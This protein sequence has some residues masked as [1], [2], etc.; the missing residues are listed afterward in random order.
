MRTSVTRT[1]LGGLLAAT[2]GVGV[3]APATA[4]PT[5]TV[6]PGELATGAAPKV[7]WLDSANQQIVRPG[8]SPLT[9]PQGASYLLHAR[10]GYVT[11]VISHI[12]RREVYRIVF[13]GDGGRRR[14]VLP[15]SRRGPDLVSADGRWLVLSSDP[16]GVFSSRQSV[17][18]VRIS[19]GRTV[20][21]RTFPAGSSPTAA[22][23]GRVVVRLPGRTVAWDVRKGSTRTLTESGSARGPAED[24]IPPG[25][26]GAHSFVSRAPRRD[27][28]RGMG[29]GRVL[30]R[31]GLGEYVLS[32]SPDDR[33]V[34]T[35]IEPTWNQEMPFGGF[36]T[37]LRVRDARTG[38]LLRTFKGYFGTDRDS[39]PVWESA[40]A[41]LL[42][43]TGEWVDDPEGE[44]HY[45]DVS[46]VRCSVNSSACKKVP[47]QPH[48]TLLQRKSN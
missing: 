36:A 26:F 17:Q 45:A 22:A 1:L 18:V 20:G 28:V 40:T 38:K 3:G 30:W 24:V 25:S 42:K 31:T 6:D 10:G 27:E 12:G 29:A 35:A 21:A 34:L 39:E 11:T 4:A 5:T 23:D 2:L 46:I 14:T 19:D 43:A 41:L 13:V 16:Y 32:Y 7:A 8:R 48:N 47:V 15:E 9:P 37:T 44:G 33:R